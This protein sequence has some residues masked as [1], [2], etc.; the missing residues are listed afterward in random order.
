MHEFNGLNFFIK[1][2]GLNP[3][4]RGKKRVTDQSQER[5]PSVLDTMTKFNPMTKGKKLQ[6][7]QSRSPIRQNWFDM[8]AEEV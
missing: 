3:Q 7:Q 8:P 6:P 4:S 2:Y 1:D 5:S